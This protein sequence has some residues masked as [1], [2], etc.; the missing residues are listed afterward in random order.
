MSKQNHKSGTRILDWRIS[1]YFDDLIKSNLS[2][3]FSIKNIHVWKVRSRGHSFL[4]RY[5]WVLRWN[6]QPASILKIMRYE[7]FRRKSYLDQIV[8]ISS[9]WMFPLMKKMNSICFNFRIE[10]FKFSKPVKMVFLNRWDILPLE[11]LWTGP[12]SWIMNIQS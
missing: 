6:F 1:K 7:N 5:F 12:H 2:T 4:K 9:I 11:R 10:L 8:K 3:T